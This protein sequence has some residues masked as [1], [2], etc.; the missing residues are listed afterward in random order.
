MITLQDPIPSV[1]EDLCGAVWEDAPAKSENDHTAIHG[2]PG[3]G[4]GDARHDSQ[5]TSDGNSL[6]MES[7]GLDLDADA[8]ASE[9]E[10]HTANLS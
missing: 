10:P 8:N 7:R 9:V 2:C 3:D 1:S 4:P 6:V 5:T